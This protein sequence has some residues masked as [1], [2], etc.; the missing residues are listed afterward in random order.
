MYCSIVVSDYIVTVQHQAIVFIVT[1]VAKLREE[2]DTFKTKATDLEQNTER[3][4][5]KVSYCI[6]RD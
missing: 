3:P 1:P 5:G 2:A 4:P 6:D